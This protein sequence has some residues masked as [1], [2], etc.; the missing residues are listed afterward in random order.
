MVYQFKNNMLMVVFGPVTYS[1]GN[2]INTRPKI[3]RNPPRPSLQDRQGG[4]YPGQTTTP[5]VEPGAIVGFAE[6]ELP[7]E[8][9][10]PA[11][12]G[13]GLF[14]DLL[15]VSGHFGCPQTTIAFVAVHRLSLILRPALVVVLV[16]Q[17]FPF[18][19]PRG[20]VLHEGLATGVEV[21][22]FRQGFPL[23]QEAVSE[24]LQ[25]LRIAFRRLPR[26]WAVSLPRSRSWA[27]F[28]RA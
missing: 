28:A 3:G 23:E 6:N 19:D 9:A 21:G 2:T 25:R 15:T 7:D 16:G 18:R 12:N 22:V 4:S 24:R 5:K 14:N 27:V 10:I 20:E 1:V 11:T 26:V 8:A 13:G 17:G